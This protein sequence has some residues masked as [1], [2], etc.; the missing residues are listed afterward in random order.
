MGARMQ[1]PG[2][3]YQRGR[4]SMVDLELTSLDQLIFILKLLIML[5]T[6]QACLM[7]SSTALIL[8]LQL[9][10]LAVA[11]ATDF[12]SIILYHKQHSTDGQYCKQFMTVSYCR[13]KIS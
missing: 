9:E 11:Y 3:P 1:W 12:A 2:N 6:K 4:L 8:P 7:R 13:S 5:V 10:F